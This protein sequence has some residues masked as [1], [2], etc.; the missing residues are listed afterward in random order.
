[1]QLHSERP[2]WGPIHDPDCPASAH[3]PRYDLTRCVC[4]AF[5][6]PEGDPVLAAA[7]DKYWAETQWAG[8]RGTGSPRPKAD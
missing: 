2:A 3:H 6:R 8:M 1:M 7:F 5:P 4:G